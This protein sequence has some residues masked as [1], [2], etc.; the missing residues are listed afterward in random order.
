MK[1]SLM[2]SAAVASLLATTGLATAQ[3]AQ[4]AAKEAPAAASPKGDSAVPMNGPA[5]KGAETATPGAASKEGKPQHAQVKPDAK[6]TGDMKAEGQSKASDSTAP[7]A[8]S[9]DMKNPTAESKPL[10]DSKTAS[11]LKAD[12]KAKAV[13]ST[14][15]SKDLKTPTAETRP[16]AP[17]SKTTGNAATSATAAPPA[18]KRTQI[19]SAIRQEKVEEVTNVNFNL[20]IGTAVPAGVRY[21]PM[22]SRI[23]EIY[24]EWRGYDFILVHGKYFVLRPRTHEI[25]YIIEG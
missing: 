10:S 24:P 4:G 5:A 13:D 8:T 11:E 2:V 23:V 22:P 7:T 16:S 14:A 20:S 15:T 3:G 12:S 25:V 9:K 19:T 18:E 21:Y 1:K 6:T 17:D